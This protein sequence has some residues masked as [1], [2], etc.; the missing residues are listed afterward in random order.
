IVGA[1]VWSADGT[2]FHGGFILGLGGI[3]GPSHRGVPRGHAGFFNRTFLQ[4]DCSAV[5]WDCMA[6]RAN[7]FQKLGGFDERHLIRQY[8]DVDFC[9]RAKES[10]WRTIWTPYANLVCHS[11]PDDLDREQSPEESALRSDKKYMRQRWK[12]ELSNDP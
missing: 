12:T 3:A 11:A 2:L 4:R 9:L 10:G 6:V 7:V 5:S 8:Q 1:R